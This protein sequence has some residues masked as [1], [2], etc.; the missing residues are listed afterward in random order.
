MEYSNDSEQD[1][2]PSFEGC[3][4]HGL[5]AF[6]QYENGGMIMN[7]ERTKALL[8]HAWQVCEYPDMPQASAYEDMLAAIAKFL[9]FKP[10]F[11]GPEFEASDL[12][13]QLLEIG[14]IIAALSEASSQIQDMIPAAEARVAAL[15][16]VD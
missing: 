6:E 3:F 15:P 7:A 11:T 4:C 9:E 14:V 13:H 5:R 2:T 12:R 16:K 1:H 10:G 8:M